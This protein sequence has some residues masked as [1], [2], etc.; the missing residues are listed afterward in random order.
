MASTLDHKRPYGTI[1]GGS[2][3]NRA[4]FE[5][6]GKEFDGA[7]REI[8]RVTV[9]KAP[10]APSETVADKTTAVNVAKDA[11]GNLFLSGEILDTEDMTVDAARALAKHMG[12]KLHPQTGKAKVLAAIMEAAGP[13]DQLA[14]QLG[15]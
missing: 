15:D 14:A 2:G 12:L 7:G 8:V 13:V 6:D 9:A 3:A 10:A 5:Q 1:H 11:Q 4:R